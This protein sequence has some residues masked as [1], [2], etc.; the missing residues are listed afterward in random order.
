M[1]KSTLEMPGWVSPFLKF[2]AIY[3]AVWGLFLVFLPQAPYRWSGLEV[4]N[5]PVLLQCLGVVLGVYSVGYWIAARDAATHWPIVLVGLLGK[6]IW[7]FVFICSAIQGGAPR[8]MYPAI[9]TNDIVWWLPLGAILLHAARVQEARRIGENGVTLEQAL[10]NAT[11]N[12]EATETNNLFDLSFQTPLLLVCVRHL[13]CTFCRE[14]IADLENQRQAVTHAGLTPVIVHMSTTEQMSQMLTQYGLSDVAQ[15]SDPE[16][17][18]FG[19]LE[20]RFGTLSQLAGFSIF[21][22]ALAEGTVFRYGFGPFAGNGL[23]LSG[24]F[25]VKDGR[26]L[27]AVRHKSA[28]ERTDFAKLSCDVARCSNSSS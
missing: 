28:A 6:F 12:R 16:R 25:I 4:P 11:I 13:G 5:Y 21:W 17:Q 20:L 8:N 1:S 23:Q 7:P 3:N 14:S 24:A 2:A 10:R 19:A 27:Q 22:R 26:I 9:V 18:L 15:V